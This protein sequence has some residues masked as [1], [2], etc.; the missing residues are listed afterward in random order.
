MMYPCIKQS[1]NENTE[2]CGKNK[3]NGLY[4]ILLYR[5]NRCDYK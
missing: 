1:K 3:S 4:F 5:S 2:V